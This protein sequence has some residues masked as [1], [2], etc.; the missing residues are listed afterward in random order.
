MSTR[1]GRWL[2]STFTPENLYRLI[3]NLGGRRFILTMAVGAA[4]TVLVWYTKITDA[5]YRDI[6][7]GTVGIYI[8]G[9][10]FQKS[11]AIKTTGATN[12]AKEEN[13]VE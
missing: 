11:T 6:I 2:D 5:I 8:A 4:S 3:V 7:L 1:F 9:N 10:T 13:K 12:V